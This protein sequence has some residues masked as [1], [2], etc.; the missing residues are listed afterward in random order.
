[1]IV[2][3]LLTEQTIDEDVLAALTDKAATQGALMDALKARINK[4]EKETI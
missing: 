2:H 4:L 1:V 3:H